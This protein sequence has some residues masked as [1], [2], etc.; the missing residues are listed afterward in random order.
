MTIRTDGYYISE[1]TP[2]VDWHAG[3]KFEGKSFKVFIFKKDN[4][5]IRVTTKDENFDVSNLNG[6]ASTD[7][8][9]K[10]ADKTIALMLNTDSDFPVKRTFTILSPEELLDENLMAYRFKQIPEDLK[11]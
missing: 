2:W 6:A 11:G 3:H 7:N 1:G 4:T 9:Y 5:C 8:A 10:I